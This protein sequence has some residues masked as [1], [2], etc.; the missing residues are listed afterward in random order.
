MMRLPNRTNDAPVTVGVDVAKATLEVGF[1]DGDSTLAL[2]N[3]EVRHEA[4]VQHLAALCSKPQAGS[5]WWW[6]PHFSSPA[7]L[8]S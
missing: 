1:S 8:W 4:L 6:P 2:N 5:I 3:D 7:T